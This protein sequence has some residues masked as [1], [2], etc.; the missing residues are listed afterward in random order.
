MLPID[1]ALLFSLLKLFER[2]R[3]INKAKGNGSF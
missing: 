1:T 3:F 2:F